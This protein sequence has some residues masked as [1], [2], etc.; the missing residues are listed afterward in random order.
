MAAVINTNIASLIAQNN[1]T[2]SQMSLQTSIQR[3]SSGLRI[4][5]ASDDAAGLAIATRMGAQVSGMTVASRNANDA[6]SLAQTADGGLATIS[7]VLT[8]MRDLAVQSANATNSST[9]RA[10]LDTEFQQLNT[11][12]GSIVST[13]KF[14][15]L[16]VIGSNAGSQTFQIGANVGDTLAVTTTNA[17]TLAVGGGVTTVSASNTA[18]TAIDS[19][20]DTLNSQRA[21]YGAAENGLNYVS[22]NL[23]N[24]IQNQTAAKSR[25]MDT[26]FAA[27]TA[28]L[29]KNQIL[30]Q[31]GTAMV[32]QANSAPNTILKLLQ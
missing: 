32:A 21:T 31:A 12:I 6:L 10:N 4:N 26:D 23:Q 14:N 9:D 24:G 13:T 30:Q 17:S 20:L 3:L 27:E 25:I 29:T 8:R 28:N 2:K 19:A 5:G 1:L 11:E 22:E 7:D 15:G 16:A 18:I